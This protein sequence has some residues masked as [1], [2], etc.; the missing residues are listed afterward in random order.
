MF[1]QKAPFHRIPLYCFLKASKLFHT[2]PVH[3]LRTRCSFLIQAKDSYSSN[4]IHPFFTTFYTYFTLNIA[5]VYLSIF[6]ITIKKKKNPFQRLSQYFAGFCIQATLS[7]RKVIGF[8][9][10]SIMPSCMLSIKHSPT[11]LHLSH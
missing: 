2:L 11:C 4:S 9:N 1:P 10:R 6:R 7:W 5:K 3:S 8:C